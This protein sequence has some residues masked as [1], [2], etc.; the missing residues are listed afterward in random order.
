MDGDPGFSF[1]LREV[2]VALPAYG[3][4]MALTYD[5]GFFYGIGIDYFTLFSLGEH[6][7]FAL[8]ALPVAFM[9]ALG[10]PC[11]IAAFG[12]GMRAE[13]A[14]A[15]WYKS[16]TRRTVFLWVLLLAQLLL[17]LALL[18]QKN[19]FFAVCSLTL[20]LACMN[21]MLVPV[22]FMRLLVFSLS[23]AIGLI[24]A[25]FVLGIQNAESVIEQN[26]ATHTLL[27]SGTAGKLTGHLIRSGDRGILFLN[28]ET[29]TVTFLLWKEI[30]QV[31]S[32]YAGQ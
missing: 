32:I 27:V 3:A 5:V 30:T 7:V 13:K 1:S 19:Y 2:L 14:G 11:G 23:T 31:Q 20:F 4:A 17:G 18:T 8:E 21:A 6:I 9:I 10:V 26:A 22:A 16:E 24:I 29:K 15:P 25:A 12:L 28:T